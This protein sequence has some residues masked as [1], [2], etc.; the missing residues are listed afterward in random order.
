MIKRVNTGRP[1]Q[2]L[3]SKKM[4]WCENGCGKCVVGKYAKGK[5]LYV[6]LRCRRIYDSKP[7]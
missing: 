5:Y 1:H 6:C 4:G 3:K 2:S 7:T